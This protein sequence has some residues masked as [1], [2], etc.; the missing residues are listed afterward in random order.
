MKHVYQ[1]N[2]INDEQVAYSPA[3]V[4]R[5]LG[6]SDN[7]VRIAIARG[8]IPVSRIG[9]KMLISKAWLTALLDA[10]VTAQKIA[11]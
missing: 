5:F 7:G 8:Q 9:A 10:E 4:A 11:A 3:Q 2:K 6:M 1:S